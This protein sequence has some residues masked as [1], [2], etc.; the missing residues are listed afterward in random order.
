[1]L[2]HNANGPCSLQFGPGE[3][4]AHYLKHKG[5]W[6]AISEDAYLKRAQSLLTQPL[7]SNLRQVIRPNGDVPRYRIS[8]NEFV[9]ATAQGRIK[10]LFRPKPG[11]AYWLTQGGSL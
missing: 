7:N 8:S 6:G 11:S 9:A 2:V 1:M 10:T 3:L 4:D 5:E